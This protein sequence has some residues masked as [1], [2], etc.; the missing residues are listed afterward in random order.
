[1]L[2]RKRRMRSRRE[3]TV[4]LRLLI[5]AFAATAPAAA[6]ERLWVNDAR[7]YGGAIASDFQSS[8]NVSG[9]GAPQNADG[10]DYR[11]G[12]EYMRGKLNHHGGFLY[13]AAFTASQA[14]YRKGGSSVRVESPTVEVLAGYGIALRPF[15]HCEFTPL[16]GIGY[17]YARISPANGPVVHNRS[18]IYEYGAMVGAYWTFDDCWQLGLVVP[19]LRTHSHPVYSYIDNG[20][21][22]VRVDQHHDREGAGAMIMLGVRY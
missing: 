17:A 7:A 21:S 14:S 20:G 8:G 6:A 10:I 4:N 3:R 11:A 18:R 1:M 15:F 13:G 12:V 22:Q 2:P 19:Y 5:L 9:S 16:A